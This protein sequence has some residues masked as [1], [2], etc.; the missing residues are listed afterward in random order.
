MC[1]VTFYLFI[2]HIRDTSFDN[3]IIFKMSFLIYNIFHMHD[4]VF[5]KSNENIPRVVKTIF[6]AGT[7]AAVYRKI[8]SHI[9]ERSPV[10]G[11]QGV[12]WGEWM[13]F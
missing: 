3:Q 13:I 2:V 11:R 1:L 10:T 6:H 7:P 8:P 12:F 5:I 4:F 9:R